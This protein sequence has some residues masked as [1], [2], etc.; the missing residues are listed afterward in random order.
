MLLSSFCDCHLRCTEMR[1]RVD[2]VR[3]GGG[4]VKPFQVLVFYYTYGALCC[5]KSAI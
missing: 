2:Q 4:E 1:V 3:E 5:M